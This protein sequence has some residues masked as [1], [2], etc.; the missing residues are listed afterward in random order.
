MRVQVVRV[1]V[2]RYGVAVLGQLAQLVVG[3]FQ[4]RA[5]RRQLV[6]RENRDAHGVPAEPPGAPDAV[7]VRGGVR[8][9]VHV[10]H[11]VDALE[12]DAAAGQV[13]G[14]QHAQFEVAHFSHRVEPL[15][16]RRR[17][18]D[19]SGSHAA[20]LD[21][22]RERFAA[23]RSLDEHDTLVERDAREQGKQGFVFTFF[24]FVE[25]LVTRAKSHKKLPHGEQT[26]RGLCAQLDARRVSRHRLDA[27]DGL[28]RVRRRE[29]QRLQRLR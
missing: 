15:R 28:G 10:H 7:R 11:Q 24:N 9:D 6:R 22:A 25:I 4:H 17:A 3:V 12:V 18:G 21:F 8:R 16:L 14:H 1:P 19:E 13:G 20:P 23:R 26:V 27:R 29:R 5:K 2:R